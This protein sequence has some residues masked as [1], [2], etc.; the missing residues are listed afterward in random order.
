MDA[1]IVAARELVA[2]QVNA[3]I[4]EH[5]H[6]S[7]RAQKKSVADG[8][9]KLLSDH[10]LMY[11]ATKSPEKAGPHPQNRATQGVDVI[12][13]HDLMLRIIKQGWSDIERR[14]ARA[15]EVSPGAEGVAQLEFQA[16]LSK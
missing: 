2:P 10:K 14:R 7:D 5:E 1:A 4:D 15:I 12:D 13:V 3:I 16:N 11:Q 6:G 8:I 9:V